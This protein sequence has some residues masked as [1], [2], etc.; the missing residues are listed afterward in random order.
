M[1]RFDRQPIRAVHDHPDEDGVR[2]DFDE[3]HRIYLDRK[4]AAPYLIEVAT[5]AWDRQETRRFL[6]KVR[7]S[8]RH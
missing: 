3:Q 1:Q 2:V 5:R 4:R 7:Q 8:R 6:D